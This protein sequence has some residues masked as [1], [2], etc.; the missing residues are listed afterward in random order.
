MVGGK[1]VGL[2]VHYDTPDPALTGYYAAEYR[3]H[4][5]GKRPAWGKWEIDEWD[6]GAGN[7]RDQVDMVQVTICK[8]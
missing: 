8:C 3:V 2:T 4:W 5:M 1:L 7:D 6:D